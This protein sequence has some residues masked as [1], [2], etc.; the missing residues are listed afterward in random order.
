MNS[1]SI[2]RQETKS[3]IIANKLEEEILSRK[4]QAGE[5]LPS[6]YELATQFNA[7]SRSVREAFKNLE[8]KGLIKV[9]QGKK[10]VVQSNSLDQ[11]V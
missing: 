2:P 5:N 10:A 7:S 6:Q 1:N 4:Y 11:F 3:T 9:Q 8:A